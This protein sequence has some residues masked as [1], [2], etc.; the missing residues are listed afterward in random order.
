VTPD[1]QL[2]P[3]TQLPPGAVLTGAGSV[4]VNAG[5]PV[6]V[7]TAR[8]TSTWPVQ[9]SSH[10]H[11]FEVNRRLVF[12]RAAAFGLRLDIP[13]GGRVRWEPGEEREVSLVPLAGERIAWSFNGLC[14]GPTTPERLA[15]ALSLAQ[16]RGFLGERGLLEGESDAV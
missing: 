6:V 2:P 10:F 16:E 5:R 7:I 13:A 15:D 1:A 12:D 9:V 11:F 4:I 8:N 3:D 14:D